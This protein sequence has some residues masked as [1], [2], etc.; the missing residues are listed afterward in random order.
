M[1]ISLQPRGFILHESMM[2][3]A[4]SLALVVGI[5]QVLSTVARQRHQGRQY[6]VAVAEAGN[7]M[8]ALVASP[9][10]KT[11]AEQAASV[12]LSP[13]CTR[14]L[15]DAELAVD[16]VD[17]EEDVRR[18]SVRIAWRRLPGR[19]SEPVHLVGWKFRHDEEEEE[20]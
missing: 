1:K 11:N 19:G 2:A 15:P 9:W 17:W 5:A 16:V 7:L 4:L 12:D 6:S 13:A 10:A 14:C 8:E 20:S 18:I 3:V